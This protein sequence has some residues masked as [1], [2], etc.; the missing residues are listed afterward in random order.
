MIEVTN[1]TKT[2]GKNRG[3]SNISFSIPEG[4]VVGFL[5]PNGAGK[6][7][8]MNIITGYFS[9]DEGD[10]KIAGIDILRQP[11]EAKRRIGYLPEHPPLYNT[12]TVSENLDFAYEIKAAK[13]PDRKEHIEKICELTGISD[14]RHRVIGHLSKGYKQRVGL[15]QALIGDPEVLVLDEPTIGLDPRQIVEIRELIKKLGK[16]R[17]I[18]LSSHILSEVS[19][20]CTRVL[21][22]SNGIIIAD[23]E[24]QPN[25][26]SLEDLFL[27]LTGGKGRK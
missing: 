2:Y 15:A 18:I 1:V 12:M 5:G 3:V 7:T 24:L 26:T 17:T 10:V 23:K 4:E 20:I 27:K 19:V 22:I 9:A 16:K 14:V 11:I 25:D 8:T 13:R 6:T 21:V